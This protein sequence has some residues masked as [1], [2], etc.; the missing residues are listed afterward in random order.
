MAAR[1]DDPSAAR[2]RV[3][4]IFPGAL[5]DLI[6][7]APAL[8]ALARRHRGC[9][10]ELMAREEL[11]RF[12]VGRMGIE[13]GHSIDRREVSALFQSPEAGAAIAEASR[14]FGGFGTIYSFFSSDNHRFRELLTR[15]ASDAEVSAHRF[16][17]EGAGHVAAGYLRS[18][19]EPEDTLEARIDLLPADLEAASRLLG[20]NRLSPRRFA[21]LLPGSGSAT[22]NWPAAKFADLADHLGVRMPVAILLGPA[23]AGLRAFF[24]GR[25]CTVLAN[26]ELGEAAAI[27]ASASVFVGNDSGLSHLS[28]AAGTPGIVLFGATDPARWRPLGRV[29]VL[30][31]LAMLQVAEVAGAALAMLQESR[32]ISE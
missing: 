16:R 29:S 27:A 9:S 18:L 4:V 15:A 22:K 20:E 12:S 6:C 32:L 28:A 26:L 30:S 2:S 24:T 19:G 17:P 8:R 25:D 1:S 31:P 23:E 13:R 5:G 7:L 21:L 11:A 10:I 14:F 3:L